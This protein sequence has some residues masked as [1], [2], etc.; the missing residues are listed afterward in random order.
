MMLCFGNNKGQSILEIAIVV[1]VFLLI[2]MGFVEWG[3]YF[4][5]TMTL[6]D[7]SFKACRYA[8]TRKGW[9]TSQSTLESEVRTKF[10]EGIT[11]VPD[12]VVNV[13]QGNIDIDFECALAGDMNFIDYI[14]VGMDEL[15]YNTISGIR[16]GIP[17]KISFSTQLRYEH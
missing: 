10:L 1:P 7:S 2:M 13:S 9:S 16:Y 8:V 17:S 3:I 4:F 11:H 14:T 5:T 15:S 6:D 12:S